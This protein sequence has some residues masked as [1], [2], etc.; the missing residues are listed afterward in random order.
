MYSL[1][2]VLSLNEI[3]LPSNSKVL[4]G[5]TYTPPVYSAPSSMPHSGSIA[6]LK[7]MSGKILKAGAKKTAHR[8][9]KI[10]C[11]LGNF[12]NISAKK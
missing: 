1:E 7:R 11:I 12:R 2:D 9:K 8:I 5:E 3:F 6:A 4:K 10:V